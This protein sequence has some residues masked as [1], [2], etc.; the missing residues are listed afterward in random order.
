[1]TEWAMNVIV[2]VHDSKDETHIESVEIMKWTGSALVPDKVYL[3]EGVIRAIKQK[4]RIVTAT[5]ESAGWK[6][7]AEVMVVLINGAEYIKTE[8]DGIEKDNLGEL[9]KF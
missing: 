2:R 4:V 5:R 8:A 1:M 6:L 3:R 7:G 9:P